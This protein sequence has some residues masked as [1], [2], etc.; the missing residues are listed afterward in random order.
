MNM[1][2]CFRRLAAIAG[3]ASLPMA[4]SVAAQ[5]QHPSLLPAPVKVQYDAGYMDL[6]GLC[7]APRTSSAPEDAFT[8][9]SLLEGA[10]GALEV[11]SGQQKP[12]IRIERSGPVAALPTPGETP[13]PESREAYTIEISAD[14]VLVKGRSS[15]GEF[16]GVQ[17]LLQMIERG[18][19]GA[20]RL[21][22]A[23]VEDWPAL[24]YRGTLMDAGSEGPML[25]FEE[26]KH[27]ID[28]I[29]KWKGNQYFFYSEG[30]IELHGYPLLNPQA[31]FTQQQIREI[32][33][34]ARERHIDVI[35]AVEMYGH[36]H[37]L[38]RIEAYWNLSDSPHG[39]QFDANNPRVKAVL[40][41]W[42]SQIG[43]LFPSPFVDVGFDETWSLQKAATQTANSTPVLLFI[44][45]L[46]TV[47]NLFQAQGK[48]VMA[49]ADIMVKFPGI[50]ERLPKGVIALPWAYEAQPDPEYHHWL[51][52]LIAEH[53][54]NIV[55]SGVMSWDEI[56][57]DFTV[58]FDNI[59]TLL[60]A[61]RRS[62]SLGLLNT[63]WTD[64]DQ[65][66]MQMSWPGIAYGT[67]AAWQNNPMPQRSFFADYARIQYPANIASDFAAALTSLNTAERD[68]HAAVGEETTREFWRDPFTTSSLNGLQGKYDYLHR[69][70]LEAEDAL[71]HFYAI[72]R[73][74]SGTP[75][76][77]S[78]IFGAQAVDLA[79]LKF[80][81]AGEIAT[82]W[83]SLP[84]HP[85]RE[86]FL[87]A[88]GVGV[89]NETHSRMM[90][91]MDGVTGT[92]E[93]YRKAWLEQYTPYRLGTAIGHWDA[94][95]LFW[96][97][98]QHNFEDFRRD[99]QSGQ[100]LPSLHDLVS[101]EP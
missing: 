77:D 49:Y 101:A 69:S 50:V 13:G 4:V 83:Q 68:L 42:A 97:R 98:A 24:A 94:E 85:T 7:A 82:A 71:T 72:Q 45:Q 92:R 76:L 67:S 10:H 8:L 55:S 70:R 64:N 78:F 22:Y 37:D 32:V 25:T 23:R 46:T 6:A 86:Q 88:V 15:A 61:G 73:A 20:L 18:P 2:E 79:D 48:T 16:Y 40:A 62:H 59:D 54:P 34:Y 58:T 60:I 21:P 5:V 51:D 44:Q 28:F 27:Q 11:C 74:A 41:D 3:M 66:L 43:A 36:L 84:E 75:H 57:P 31:R 29:A 80:I 1:L 17:T 100:A 47:A 12:S 9:T 39:G 91:M 81:Y 19:D 26:V 93:L 99:F 89:S 35:P 63:L 33:G 30:N 96:L 65:M 56:T 90:D 52:P 87:D 53:V 14:G 38:F 95:Y